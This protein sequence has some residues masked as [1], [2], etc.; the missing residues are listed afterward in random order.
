[1][2]GKL[3]KK[4]I[5]DDSYFSKFIY[6]CI[7]DNGTGLKVND[8]EIV[9]ICDIIRETINENDYDKIM[10]LKNGSEDDYIKKLKEVK[11]LLDYSAGMLHNFSILNREY[12]MEDYR[13]QNCPN[14]P[15][16]FHSLWLCNEMGL[17]YWKTQLKRKELELYKMSLTGNLFLT[18]GDF[19]PNFGLTREDVKE[20]SSVYWNPP[21]ERDFTKDE[22]LFQG[23]AK[24]LERIN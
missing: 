18:N 2:N 19:L 11:K 5:I 24:I 10:N 8:N 6:K 16:R 15:S 21:K 13:L 1:M 22:Y 7:Y 9:P 17:D 20:A 23:K 4:I 14:L 3:T 12:G